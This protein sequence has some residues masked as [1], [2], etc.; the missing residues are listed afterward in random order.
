GKFSGEH[1]F[2]Q[3]KN[4][5]RILGGEIPPGHPNSDF[6][7]GECK[8]HCPIPIIANVINFG[9]IQNFIYLWFKLIFGKNPMKAIPPVEVKFFVMPKSVIGVKSDPIYHS[10]LEDAKEPEGAKDAEEAKDAE[11][12]NYLIAS[13]L[14][15]S[16]LDR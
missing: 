13:P 6:N 4:S 2:P 14:I 16:L 11:Y 12:P 5:G 9:C 15:T 7:E 10:C 3:I 8:T 1:I